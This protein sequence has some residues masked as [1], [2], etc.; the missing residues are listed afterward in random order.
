MFK[1][2]NSKIKAKMREKAIARAQTRI[3]IAGRRPE[4]LSEEDLEIVVRE[5]ED[6]LK[7]ELKEKGF[8][9]ILALLGVNLFT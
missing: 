8:L 6:K 2:L 9:A 4:E 3:I 7:S 5:E 1:S